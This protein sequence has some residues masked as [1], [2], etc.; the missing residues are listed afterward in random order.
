MMEQGVAGIA[1]LVYSG[2]VVQQKQAQSVWETSAM[3]MQET[4]TSRKFQAFMTRFEHAHVSQNQ[5]KRG[6]SSAFTHQC[7]KAGMF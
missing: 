5:D 2:F 1:K 7:G 3:S 4:I 6:G